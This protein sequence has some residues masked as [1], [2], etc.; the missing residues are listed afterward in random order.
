MLVGKKDPGPSGDI[1]F[2]DDVLKTT[3]PGGKRG[4]ALL[5]RLS[6]VIFDVTAQ[7]EDF[8]YELCH[9]L[10]NDFVEDFLETEIKNFSSVPYMEIIRYIK[11][12]E[13]ESTE[14]YLTFAELFELDGDIYFAEDLEL[15]SIPVYLKSLSFYIDALLTN[16]ELIPENYTG[17]I[18]NLIKIVGD[19]E[20]PDWAVFHLFKYHETSGQYGKAEDL[21]F[22]LLGATSH[23]DLNS[24]K[25]AEDKPGYSIPRQTL[26][27]EGIAF[28]NRV[29]SQG[30]VNLS[31]G[32]LPINE[33]IEGLDQL[34]KLKSNQEIIKTTPHGDNDNNNPARQS[35]SIKNDGNGE[36][37]DA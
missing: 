8:E 1:L 26:I 7:R 11:E 6:A 12:A 14:V 30:S 29:I 17:K 15:K 16:S 13:L 32:N 4:A 36:A 18:N 22:E 28:Y 35:F 2:E 20:M 23:I 19:Y 34:I 25:T 24:A 3:D 21:L 31:M 33:A 37:N 27:D 5:E 10:I 9:K